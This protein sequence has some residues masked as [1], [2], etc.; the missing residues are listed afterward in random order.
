VNPSKDR[1]LSIVLWHLYYMLHNV[2]VSICYFVLVCWWW[3]CIKHIF[4]LNSQ[5]LELRA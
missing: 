2:V 4:C 3:S 5:L 1:I